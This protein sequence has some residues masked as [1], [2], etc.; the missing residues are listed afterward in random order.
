MRFSL[1][2]RIYTALLLCFLGS[3]SI[4]A[5]DGTTISADK[6]A[7]TLRMG[8]FKWI[9]PAKPAEDKMQSF[10]DI[11]KAKVAE[12][13]ATSGR[14]E[15]L[16]DEI[17]EDINAY[18]Q[19]EAFMNVPADQYPTVL[20]GLMN[21]NLLVG[22]ITKCKFTKRTTGAKGYLCMLAL[23]LSVANAYDKTN[24]ISSRMFVSSLKGKKLIVRNTAEA[25]LDDALQSITDKLVDYFSHN[26]SVYGTLVSYDGSKAILSCGS[27]QGVVEGD[28]F[29][30]LQVTMMDGGK[31][32]VNIALKVLAELGQ[33]IPVCGMVKDDRH[34]TR[35]LYFN[36]EELP[37]DT[38][39]EG[40]RLITRIQ[41]ETH[42][43]AI[44][45][46]KSLRG[47]AGVHSIL[48]DIPGIG[49]RRRREL[50]RHFRDIESLKAASEEELSKVPGMDRRAAAS[51]YSFFHDNCKI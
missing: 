14:F 1:I 48:D 20:T 41:D 12:T 33:D 15:V 21:D 43:F 26:F 25:A 8:E 37:I 2:N 44:E 38:H 28:E 31:G 39:S 45:Y 13:V 30:V 10:I 36:N 46:H 42:R 27:P 50:M 24:I 34:R 5:Q 4:S 47:K 6:K 9:E 23:K 40:F 19:S 3:I 22:E 35:G 51:V 49:P 17:T 29:Q 7:M 32:Q 11:I 18:V 16:D